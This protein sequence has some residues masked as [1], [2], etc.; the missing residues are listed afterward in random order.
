MTILPFNLFDRV[1]AASG[2]GDEKDEQ[3]VQ[4]KAKVLR[5][6]IG[7]RKEGLAKV[8]GTS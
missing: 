8:K 3:R 6:G 1:L 5:E 4:G 7:R 2:E